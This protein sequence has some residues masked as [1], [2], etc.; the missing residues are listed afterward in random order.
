MAGPSNEDIF[1]FWINL[2]GVMSRTMEVFPT[3]NAGNS[4]VLAILLRQRLK[5][6]GSSKYGRIQM[7]SLMSRGIL[8]RG[9]IY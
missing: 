6:P 7:V 4:W 3:R 5:L 2:V 1:G 9:D 8:R